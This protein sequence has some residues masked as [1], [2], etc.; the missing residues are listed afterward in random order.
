MP[1]TKMEQLVGIYT[2]ELVCFQRM[3]AFANEQAKCVAVSNFTVLSEILERRQG[4]ADEINGLAA[5]AQVAA[6][7]LA[8]DL[9]LPEANL[10]NLRLR[11]PE[12][13]VAPLERALAQ[14]REVAEEIQAI[15]AK[16]E[17]EVRQ[18]MQ[19]LRG[20]MSNVQRGQTAMRAYKNAPQPHDARF[21]DKQK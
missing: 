17:A 6:Q 1:T 16:C 12:A 19:G 2:R 9:A 3:L 11:L 14:L 15:D 5:E 10:S 8:T 20:E 21:I 7:G 4:L 18:A 13:V